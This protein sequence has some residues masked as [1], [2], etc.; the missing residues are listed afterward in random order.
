MFGSNDKRPNT[1]ARWN[2]A[3]ERAHAE[4][5]RVRLADG[6]TDVYRVS[7]GRDAGV[8]Y[9][10]DATYCTCDACAHGD[11][12]CKHRAAVRSALRL[13][14]PRVI[15]LPI[16]PAPTTPAPAAGLPALYLELG[17]YNAML[18]TYG[19]LSDRDYRRFVAIADRVAELQV[20]EEAA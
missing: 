11:P 20:R 5:L 3:L 8:W 17:R 4:G 1:E 19:R 15:I 13:A 2:A 14:A 18:A 6:E 9:F 16:D 10:T 12:V 7:S